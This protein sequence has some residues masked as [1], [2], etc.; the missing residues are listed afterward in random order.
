MNRSPAYGQRRP[1]TCAKPA[2]VLPPGAC[3]YMALACFSARSP[4]IGSLN[5]C[6]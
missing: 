4:I 3:N 6:P 2:N 5:I 1:V